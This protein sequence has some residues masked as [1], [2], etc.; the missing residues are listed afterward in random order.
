MASAGATAGDVSSGTYSVVS[1]PSVSHGDVSGLCGADEL[2][3][4]FWECDEFLYRSTEGHEKAHRVFFDTLKKIL[5]L[6]P[7]PNRTKNERQ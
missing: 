7:R 1:L 6:G 5:F 3:L 2:D 4:P